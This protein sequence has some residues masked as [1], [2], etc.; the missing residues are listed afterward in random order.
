MSTYHRDA[1]RNVS[2]GAIG[3]KIQTVLNILDSF[4]RV[5]TLRV[6]SAFSLANETNFFLKGKLIRY[7]TS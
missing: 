6:P 5:P 3:L 7:C 1:A 2:K 4:D